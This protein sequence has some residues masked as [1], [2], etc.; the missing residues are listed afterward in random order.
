MRMLALK[1]R[2]VRRLLLGAGGLT[3]IA[4][5]TTFV[6]ISSRIGAEVRAASDMARQQH[7][8]D[9][10]EALLRFVA[11]TNHSPGDRNRAVWALGQLGDRR[12][13][14]VLQKYYSGEPCDHRSALCQHELRKAIKL[15]AGGVNVTAMVWRHSARR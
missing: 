12:A 13:L 5:A 14:P 9:P 15:A 8:G 1:S 4:V 2:M 6:V 10:V 7:A 11:D 3:L